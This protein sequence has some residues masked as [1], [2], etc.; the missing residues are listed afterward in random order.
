MMAAD[1][2]SDTC[3]GTHVG[4]DLSRVGGAIGGVLYSNAS[5]D[6]A[7]KGLILHPI[8]CGLAFI[9]QIVALASVQFGF[10]F[11]SLIVFLAFLVSLVCM[12]LNFAIFGIVRNHINS[13]VAGA[14]AH[15]GNATWLVL[16]ATISLLIATLFTLFACCCGGDRKERKYGRK[17]QNYMDD[18]YVGNQPAMTQNGYVGTQPGMTQN[19]YVG[20]Q[21]AMTQ[22]TYAPQRK[23]WWSKR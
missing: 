8:A 2:Q 7:T 22:T 12:V 13:N 1:D 6:R 9:A 15:F 3:T 16:A 14:P 21:P 19:G 17:H 10:L 4:Y 5:A 20:N 18:G 23:H 11:A